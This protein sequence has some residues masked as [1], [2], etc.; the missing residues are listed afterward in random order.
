MEVLKV[1]LALATATMVV[2][3][4]LWIL[5]AGVARL[6]RR[7]TQEGEGGGRAAAQDTETP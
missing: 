2:A 4:V 5:V 7:S 1:L 3:M 6:G